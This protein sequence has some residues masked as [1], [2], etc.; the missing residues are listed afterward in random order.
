MVIVLKYLQLVCVTSLLSGF[1]PV[2]GVWNVSPTINE[3]LLYLFLLKLWCIYN[4]HFFHTVSRWWSDIYSN[5][6]RFTLIEEFK[7]FYAFW[8]S[9]MIIL[10]VLLAFSG[11]PLSKRRCGP[12]HKKRRTPSSDSNCGR[13]LEYI[14]LWGEEKLLM[15]KCFRKILCSRNKAPPPFVSPSPS[16]PRSFLPQPNTPPDTERAKLCSPP[17]EIR[18]TGMEDRDRRCWGDS[19]PEFLLPRPSWPLESRPHAYTWPSAGTSQ[20]FKLNIKRATLRNFSTLR[21]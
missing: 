8:Q 1:S 15:L 20:T 14:C 3:G 16:W 9:N 10:V 12:F 13:R 18:T 4:K 7:W 11:W 5:V 6:Q 19:A 2:G 21:H 17:A